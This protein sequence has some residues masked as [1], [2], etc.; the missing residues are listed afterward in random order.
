MLAISARTRVRVGMVRALIEASV[1]AVGWLL[2]GAAGV[3]T[4]MF[5]FGIGPAVE[6]AFQLLRVQVPAGP[7]RR[8]RRGERACAES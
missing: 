5:A 7:D 1:L 4:I 8:T 2:G 3:G 6:L